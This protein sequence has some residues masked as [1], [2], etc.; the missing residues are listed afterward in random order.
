MFNTMKQVMLARRRAASLRSCDAGA[1][2]LDY[3]SQIDSPLQV[4]LGVEHAPTPMLIGIRAERIP[5]RH[6]FSPARWLDNEVQ[7]LE[8][9][10]LEQVLRLRVSPA[11][12][13]LI[14]FFFL[15]T[16]PPPNSPL[17]PYRPLFQ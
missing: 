10:R 13:L 3:P 1:S 12:R 5:T 6:R 17:F 11:S 16:R 4:S 8:S 9:D 7:T 15:I 14:Y 2:V